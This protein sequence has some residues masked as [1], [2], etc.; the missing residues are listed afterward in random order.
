MS[1]ISN[2]IQAPAGR[3][4]L[5]WLAL[6]FAA[7]LPGGLGAAPPLP[8]R[9]LLIELREADAS[10]ASS[11][12]AGWSV[13]SADAS[14]AR[15]RPV[16]QLRVKNGASAGLRLT[17]TR[18]L[19]VWQTVPGALL[20]V[21]MPQTQWITAGQSMLL[22]PRWP[23]GRE[24]VSVTLSS[25]SSRFDPHVAPGSAELPQR[26]EA[27]VIT[28]VSAP[29]GQWVTLA[30]TG[31]DDSDMNVVASGQAAARHALQLRVSLLP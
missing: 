25:D 18:P 16:Q 19:Q 30:A 31:A 14:M 27:A 20:P 29:L 3:G 8:R 1:K 5:A 9:D 13:R 7:L 6:L 4:R 28:T 2:A 26:T 17:V 10:Q 12:S 11:G 22:Q 24:P 21:P 15:E 23:G